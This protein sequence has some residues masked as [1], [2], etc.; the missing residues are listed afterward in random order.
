MLFGVIRG[1]LADISGEDRLAT[2]PAAAF[3]PSTA[4]TEGADAVWSVVGGRVVGGRRGDRR[5]PALQ[6]RQPGSPLALRV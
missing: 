5:G 6:G 1:E 3:P 2:L 4:G